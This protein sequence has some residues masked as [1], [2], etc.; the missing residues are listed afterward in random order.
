MANALAAAVGIE[1]IGRTA[2]FVAGGAGG[3]RA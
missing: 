3:V 2:G 1:T